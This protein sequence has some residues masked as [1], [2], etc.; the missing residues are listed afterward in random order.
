MKIPDKR[1]GFKRF[2]DSIKYS[3]Q[4]IYY[5]YTKEQSLLIHLVIT[6]ILVIMGFTFNISPGEWLT[7]IIFLGVI[8]ALELFNTAIE[9][10]VD[11]VTTEYNHLA[12]VAKDCSSAAVFLATLGGLI[13]FIIVYAPKIMEL[14][15]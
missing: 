9:A 7:T 2:I 8:V 14:L 3:L 11:L 13:A 1:F 12:K 6:I 5:T 4:G 15:S 10:V